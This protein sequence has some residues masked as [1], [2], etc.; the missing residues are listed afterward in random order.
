[1]RGRMVVQPKDSTV[2]IPD[3]SAAQTAPK[4]VPGVPSSG[5]GQ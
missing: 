4:N 1:M 2:P 3:W 5:G